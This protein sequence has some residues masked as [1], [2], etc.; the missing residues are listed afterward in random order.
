MSFDRLLQEKAA[1]E[2]WLKLVSVECNVTPDTPPAFIWH[3]FTDNSVPVEN[4]L[5]L[6]TAYKEAN[7]NFEL[8]IF[9]S[10]THGLGLGTK[11]TDTKDCKHY[12]PEVSV[13]TMSYIGNE[14][15]K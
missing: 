3:T 5:M 14:V 8:H 12:C 4:S 13:W 7:V 10:G 9:P 11:E 2:K 15:I 6:A 1:D